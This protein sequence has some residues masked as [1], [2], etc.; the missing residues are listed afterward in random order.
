MTA[1]AAGST[2]VFLLPIFYLLEVALK[3]DRDQWRS[4]F[5]WIFRPTLEHF[6]TLVGTPILGPYLLNSVVVT[7]CTAV[8]ALL[9]G[10]PAAYV[11]ER[12]PF[13]GQSH[14]SMWFL[15]Q[16]M[17]PPVAMVIPFYFLIHQLGLL[18]TRTGLILVYVTFGIPLTVWLMRGFFRNL[19]GELEQAALVD[20]C[21]WFGTF[22]WIALP[23]SL[24][25]ILTT[26]V[27][28]VIQSWNEFLFA[29]VL[30]GSSTYTLPVSITTFWTERQVFWGQ[31]AAAGIIMICPVIIFGLLIQRHLV[32]GLTMGAIEGA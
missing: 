32:R 16:L 9:V 12:L 10:V 11:L 25:G 29:L 21:S 26:A 14:L 22:R 27:F 8:I 15:G 17:I 28:L 1:L 20:G 5:L 18:H 4:Q 23:L 30:T 3:T 24:P 13:R 6:A 7:V 2:L 31:I 19:P